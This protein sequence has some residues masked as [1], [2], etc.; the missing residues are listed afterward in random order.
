MF[1]TF[2]KYWDFQ[3][4]FFPITKGDKDCSPGMGR[5]SQWRLPALL[6]DVNNLERTSENAVG[7]ML[8][9]LSLNHWITFSESCGCVTG[10]QDWDR[11]PKTAGGEKLGKAP[12]KI[13]DVEFEGRPS[14][15][16]VVPCPRHVRV[17]SLTPTPSCLSVWLPRWHGDTVPREWGKVRRIWAPC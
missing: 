12:Q 10:L 11:S 2:T 6:T 14:S 5:K 4:W 7:F 13:S 15:S 16:L 8:W 3:C 17:S 1:W 9:F